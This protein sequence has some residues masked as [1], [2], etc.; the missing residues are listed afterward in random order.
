LRDIKN[1]SLKTANADDKNLHICHRIKDTWMKTIAVILNNKIMSV[2]E[3]LMTNSRGDHFF[4][5]TR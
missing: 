1:L 5:D 3:I 2:E 4:R